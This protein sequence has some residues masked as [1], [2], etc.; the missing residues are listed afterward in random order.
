MLSCL[1]RRD[2][3]RAQLE[4]QY[5]QRIAIGAPGPRGPMGP[6]ESRLLLRGLARQ[7]LL[8]L[9]ALCRYGWARQMPAL[10][11]FT[12]AAPALTLSALLPLPPLAQA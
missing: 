2:V 6:G 9:A 10:V 8:L 4:T 12:G 11:A 5:Q 1:Q 3:R 7:L